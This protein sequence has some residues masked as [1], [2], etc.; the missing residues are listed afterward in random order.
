MLSKVL[1]GFVILFTKPNII[2]IILLSKLSF[3]FPDK[4]YLQMMYW[5][6]LGIP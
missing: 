3:L 1:K 5:L 6:H 4:L 2:G